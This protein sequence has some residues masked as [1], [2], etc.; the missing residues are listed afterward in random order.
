[1]HKFWRDLRLAARGLRRSPGFTV[2]VVLTLALG[3]GANTSIFSVVNAVL[4]RPLPYRQPDRLVVFW[5]TFPEIGEG[6]APITEGAFLDYQA[7]NDVLSSISGFR[8]RSLDNNRPVTLTGNHLPVA[9]NGITCS[10]NLFDT[11]GVRPLRGRLFTEA[12][13]RQGAPMVAVVSHAFWIKHLG[14]DPDAIGRKVTLDGVSREV[15]GILPPE[16]YFPPPL[17]VMGA[18]RQGAADVF[19][20]YVFNPDARRVRTIRAVARLG[21]GVTLQQADA[22]LDALSARLAEEFKES[23]IKGQSVV[24]LPI[25]DQAV[26]QSRAVLLILMGGV[27]VILLIACVNVANMFLART[28]TRRREMAIRLALGAGGRDIVRQLL[29]ESLLLSIVGGAVGL[30]FASLSLKALVALTSA[31]VP[32]LGPVAIDSSV[33]LFTLAASLLTGLF[34]GLA[35]AVQ[36]AR[37]NL[38]EEL[39]EGERGNS[40]G[41]AREFFRRALVVS[42]VSLAFVLL[43]GAG[44]LLRSLWNL[45]K[46]DLGFDPQNVST[47]SALPPQAKYPAPE[48]IAAFFEAVIEELRTLPGVEGVAAVSQLPLSGGLFGGQFEVLGREAATPEELEAQ[49]A[50]YRI[51]SDDYLRTLKIPL[52]DGRDFNS[53]DRADTSP[54]ALIDRTLAARLWPD[55]QWV[56]AQVRIADGTPAFS[57][58]GVVDEIRSEDLRSENLGV[59]YFPLRQMPTRAMSLAIRTQRPPESVADEIRQHVRKIDPDI[60]IQ[61]E[62]LERYVVQ[63]QAGLRA[64]A[65]LFGSFAALAVALAAVGLYGLISYFVGQRRRE[66]GIRLAL[67]AVRGDIIR[68]IGLQTGSIILAGVLIGLG[69]A[70]ILSRF[71]LDL[72]FGVAPTDPPTYA[73]VTLLLFLAAGLSAYLPAARASRVEPI[74]ALRTE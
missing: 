13:G 35:P 36:A 37:P 31:H 42:Q 9:L 34:F 15:V 14:G 7:R 49:R 23:A 50:S 25:H 64:P 70:L 59:I 53:G 69:A 67:G 12:D 18:L 65:T 51:I 58:V 4:L 73:A 41:T 47:F 29:V 66:I 19:Y 3:V 57:I 2:V 24:L 32:R 63:A 56:T 55:R 22:S 44:L 1:M 74:E 48:S 26:A 43:I 60:A 28:L 39:K 8:I 45:Q 46:T 33:L 61:V 21:D 11:L 6:Y 54:V 38:N 40:G 27:G 52:L 62:P 71:L 20:P 10:S 68:R 16:F 30:L 17:S 72:L 5:E